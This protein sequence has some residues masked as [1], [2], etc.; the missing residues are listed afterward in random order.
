MSFYHGTIRADSLSMYTH[1][2]VL[3]PDHAA[4]ERTLLLLHGLSDNCDAWIRR[5]AIGR[6]TDKYRLAVVM[7]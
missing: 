7:P 5:T 2:N 6:L 3:L 4:P 1:V